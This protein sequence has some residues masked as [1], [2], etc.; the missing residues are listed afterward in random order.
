MN[1]LKFMTLFG[2]REDRKGI[3]E[4][5]HFKGDMS[6]GK[7]NVAVMSSCTRYDSLYSHI[8]CILLRQ[9]LQ[10]IFI[11]FLSTR[12]NIFS[13]GLSLLSRITYFGTC[14]PFQ[15]QFALR[16][17]LLH[18]VFSVYFYINRVAQPVCYTPYTVHFIP[19]YIL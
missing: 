9:S 8:C 5:V 4:S 15:I 19:K 11:T 2:V 10:R 14:E 7:T 12:Y 17:Q 18:H 1:A 3:M 16:V 6:L 13:S